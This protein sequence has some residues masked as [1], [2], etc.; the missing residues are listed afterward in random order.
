MTHIPQVAGSCLGP[1]RTPGLGGA[2]W[3]AWDLTRGGGSSTCPHCRGLSRVG[4]SGACRE[5]W[6][7]AGRPP[8]GAGKGCGQVLHGCGRLR[9]RPWMSPV[10][11]ARHQSPRANTCQ[12]FI[13]DCLSLCYGFM[14][15][16]PTVSATGRRTAQLPGSLDGAPPQKGSSTWEGRVPGHGH[17]WGCWGGAPNSSSPEGTIFPEAG[18]DCK[19]PLPKSDLR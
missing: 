4:W 10:A 17:K 2:G 3:A 5:T 12:P 14:G 6:A 1:H 7:R 18:S 8:R 19:N 9:V 13:A 16:Q 15:L 11:D